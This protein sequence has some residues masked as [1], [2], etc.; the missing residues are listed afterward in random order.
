[1][2]VDASKVRVGLTGAVSKAPYGTTGPTDVSSSLN[3]AFVDVG[4][5]SEDGVTI[6]SPDA[7]DKTVIKMW[8]GSAQV[9]VLRTASDD[10]PTIKF[11][12]LETNKVAVETYFDTTVTAAATSG[13]FT[14][15][16]TVPNPSAYVLDVVDGA[17]HHRYHI[18]RGVRASVGDLVYS[19]GDPVGYE[20]T[21]ECETDPT[22]GYPIKAWMT[23]LKTPA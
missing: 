1:M 23:D 16:P 4:A 17:E 13:S 22:L 10:L 20:I 18:P 12:I 2:A 7:G 19:N 14:F 6:T 21:L 8:Q 9:R 3:T 15:T 11:T 5:I